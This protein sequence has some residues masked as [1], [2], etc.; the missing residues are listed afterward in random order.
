MRRSP[1]L[2]AI[3]L[4]AA[5]VVASFALPIVSRMP[6]SGDPGAVVSGMWICPHGGGEGWTSEVYVSNPGEEPVTI[7]VAS[8]DEDGRGRAE[9]RTV[10]GGGTV[11]VDVPAGSLASSSTVEYFGGWVAA[12]WVTTAGGGRAGVAAEPCTER[13]A[14]RWYVPDMS[15]V[16]DEDDAIIVANPYAADAVFSV[17]LLTPGRE[18][19]RTDALTNVLI[20]AHR[21]A[22]VRLRKTLL[23]EATVAAVVDVSVG[24]VAV[25]SL[26]ITGTSGIRSAI[27]FTGSLE[28]P[29]VLPGALG[30]GQGD[31]I[32]MIPGSE[33][34]SLS[35][36]LLGTGPEQPVAGLAEAA[37]TGGSARAFPVAAADASAIVF[38]AGSSIGGTPS[39]AW[40]LLP[41][42]PGPPFRIGIAIAN[43]GDS[44]ITVT[45]RALGP[46][47]TPITLP[48]GARQTILVPA[49]FADGT[50]SIG[51]LVVASSGAVVVGGGSS[52]GGRV[53][54]A[55]YATA[56][57]V[58][59]PEAWIPA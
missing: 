20:R 11:S 9:E 43:P 41:T 57:A 25:A 59:V 28:E 14:A 55:A 15:T 3:G 17:T 24:R 30:T 54:N 53:G 8:L 38:D 31:L 33:G 27:G 4:L 37:P 29:V 40:I 18:P 16:E 39:T 26:D 58:P 44:P 21:S 13:T 23:G 46:G 56:L 51:V 6:S 42:V 5:G 52:S 48:I 34:I 1:S 50:A 19:T 45:V 35:A 7:R 32:T 22:A 10:P 12:G 36:A 49:A 2:L 47:P